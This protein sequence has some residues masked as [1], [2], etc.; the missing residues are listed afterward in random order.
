MG[1]ARREN[2]A[3]GLWLAFLVFPAGALLLAVIGTEP[4]VRIGI[5]VAAVLVSV[6]LYRRGAGAMPRS[7]ALALACVV[8]IGLVMMVLGYVV[9]DTWRAADAVYPTMSQRADFFSS[10]LSDGSTVLARAAQFVGR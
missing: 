1:V 2:L 8:A 6:G 7:G 5:A 3:R 10:A 4:S 9:G